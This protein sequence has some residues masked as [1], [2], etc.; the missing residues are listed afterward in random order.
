MARSHAHLPSNRRRRSSGSPNRNSNQTGFTGSKR[1]VGSSLSRSTTIADKAAYPT[2]SRSLLEFRACPTPFYYAEPSDIAAERRLVCHGHKPV[3]PRLPDMEMTDS[4]GRWNLFCARF[5][6][7]YGRDDWLA[8]KQAPLRW[9]NSKED[10]FSEYE[11]LKTLDHPH[12]IVTVGAYTKETVYGQVNVG[13]LLYPLAPSNLATRIKLCSQHNELESEQGGKHWQIADDAHRF[14]PFFACICDALSYLHRLDQPVKHKDIKTEN[15][16]I[17]KSETVILADFDRAQKYPSREAAISQGPGDRTNRFASAAV[18]RQENR[19]FDRDVAPLGFVFVEMATVVLGETSYHMNAHC[20][21]ENWFENL[22]D[23]LLDSWIEHLR[24]KSRDYPQRIPSDFTRIPGRLL[25]DTFLDIIKEMAHADI[26]EQDVLE[27]ALDF[28]RK[29]PDKACKHCGPEAVHEKALRDDEASVVNDS[30]STQS[31]KRDTLIVPGPALDRSSLRPV[32]GTSETAPTHASGNEMEHNANGQPKIKVS[33]TNTSS[34]NDALYLVGNHA[35]ESD[36]LTIGSEVK[37]TSSH[38]AAT[39]HESSTP[40]LHSNPPTIA[41]E[42]EDLN[43]FETS[44]SEDS[45]P[46]VLRIG[47]DFSSVSNIEGII[48][49]IKESRTKPSKLKLKQAIGRDMKG[50]E[51]RIVPLYRDRQRQRYVKLWNS[52][53]YL[54]KKQLPRHARILFRMGLLRTMLLVVPEV[55]QC[56]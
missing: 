35:V 27:K 19:G 7:S 18:M 14:I 45:V 13:A 54:L 36:D 41:T 24:Q 31:R 8:V 10:A 46:R 25:I 15:I 26:N 49:C 47:S 22:G 55:V 23:G 5:K 17:D 20:K 52:H 39:G 16:L 48:V 53:D 33:R 9:F 6:D 28:F 37:S 51:V 29:L 44:S 2:S 40:Q 30:E 21:R 32:N 38:D 34:E 50:N 56:V 1:T 4:G 11:L 3:N 42:S 43:P 12:I